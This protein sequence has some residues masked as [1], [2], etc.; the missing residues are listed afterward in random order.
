MP[1]HNGAASKAIQRSAAVFRDLTGRGGQY[2][3]E[4]IRVASMGEIRYIVAM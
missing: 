4:D 3:E 1:G 2:L